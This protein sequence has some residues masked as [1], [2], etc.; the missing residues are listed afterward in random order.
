[1]PDSPHFNAISLPRRDNADVQCLF[2]YSEP[3]SHLIYAAAD[4]FLVPSLF[5]PC[6]LTQ[7]IAL[8]WGGGAVACAWHGQGLQARREILLINLTTTP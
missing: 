5:E 7:L 4:M 1:M 2:M 8:R 3:L 6:G